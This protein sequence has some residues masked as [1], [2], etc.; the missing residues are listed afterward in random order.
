MFFKLN[1]TAL[2]CNCNQLYLGHKIHESKS[3]CSITKRW[4]FI[5]NAIC[6]IEYDTIGHNENFLNDL[7][8]KWFCHRNIKS[9]NIID[10]INNNES[11]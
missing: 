10:K 7:K 4:S 5:D 1:M 2:M 9:T 3:S 6:S 11:K 8:Y